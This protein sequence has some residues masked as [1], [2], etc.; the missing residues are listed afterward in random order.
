MEGVGTGL[1]SGSSAVDS[2]RNPWAV[3]GCCFSAAGMTPMHVPHSGSWVIFQ[4]S[5]VVPISDTGHYRF[6]G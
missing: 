2:L 3:L 5:N 6:S 1:F 4:K